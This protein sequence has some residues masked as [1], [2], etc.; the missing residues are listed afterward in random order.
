MYYIFTNC[1][2]FS[3]RKKV[4]LFLSRDTHT[5]TFT[6][7]FTHLGPYLLCLASVLVQFC[8]AG[9]FFVVVVVVF[10]AFTLTDFCPEYSLLKLDSLRGLMKLSL[11]AQ[12]FLPLMQTKC[13]HFL[14]YKI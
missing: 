1:I 11:L 10:F 5:L 12:Q 3:K 14:L 8:F 4:E 9:F 7:T 2:T 6:H 13:E